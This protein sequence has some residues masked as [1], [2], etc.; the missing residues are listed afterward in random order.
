MNLILIGG[1]HNFLTCREKLR[2]ILGLFSK[3]KKN[4]EFIAVEYGESFFE[5]YI[6]PQ[7]SIEVLS[8]SQIKQYEGV[9]SIEDIKRIV[10]CIASD[11]V[12]HKEFFPDVPTVWLDNER[13][14]NDDHKKSAQN[15]LVFKLGNVKD[16]SSQ[17]PL[18]FSKVDLIEAFKAHELEYKSDVKP[19]PD[20][21][22]MWVDE[23]KPHLVPDIDKYAFLIV[24]EKHTRKT[25]G[26]LRQL[27]RELGHGISII[28]LT[29]SRRDFWP[30]PKR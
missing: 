17:S 9:L 6:R 13:P 24:G 1:V 22:A 15:M 7:R 20:R 5:E 16:F 18:D 26:L 11:A 4:P 28:S 3:V 12:E 21:D 23:L 27:L 30:Q 19:S 10:P 25:K 8:E 2:E 29:D 14:Y